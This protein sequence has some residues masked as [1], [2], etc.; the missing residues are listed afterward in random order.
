MYTY[1]DSVEGMKSYENS[2]IDEN[3]QDKTFLDF[4]TSANLT[5]Q[6]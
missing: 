4:I 1:C 3:V 5:H 2:K 6:K